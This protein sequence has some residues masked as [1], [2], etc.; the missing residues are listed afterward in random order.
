MRPNFTIKLR[1]R[2]DETDMAG[3]VHFSKYFVYFGVAHWNLLKSLGISY[4]SLENSSVRPR[5]VVAHCEYKSPARYDDVLVVRAEV[6]QV[7]EKSVK[8]SYEI[9]KEDD[10]LVATG[11]VIHTFI[12]VN[13]RKSVK[14]PNWVREKL[15]GGV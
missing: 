2:I 11:Y 5:I 1:V 9:R 7:R 15:L 13:A 4:S 12:D 3:V 8:Y 14:I 6:S 10:T